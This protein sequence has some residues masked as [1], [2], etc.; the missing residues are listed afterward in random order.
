MATA[1][2]KAALSDCFK[3]SRVS[4]AMVK[5]IESVGVETLDDFAN[6]V[7]RDRYEEDLKEL[8]ARGPEQLREMDP[9]QPGA[10]AQSRLRAAYLLAVDLLKRSATKSHD[11]LAEDPSAPL[12]QPVRDQLTA[13]W[14]QHYHLQL[15]VELWPSDALVARVYREL[16]RGTATVIDVKKCRALIHACTPTE[17]KRHELG[18]GLQLEVG[19]ADSVQ[20]GSVID[21]YWGLRILAYAYAVAGHEQV[22]SQVTVKTKV[23][24]CPLDVNLDYADAALRDCM[25]LRLPGRSAL[26]WLRSRDTLTRGVMVQ[27]LRQGWPQGEALTRARREE[28]VAWK[29]GRLAFE[30]RRPPQDDGG[31]P[32]KRLRFGRGKGYGKGSWSTASPMLALED[33]PRKG[34]GKQGQMRQRQS[35][36]GTWPA[37]PKHI[38]GSTNHGA[39]ACSLSRWY[40]KI[41]YKDDNGN[42]L[43]Q[44]F[45]KG[46][47]GKQKDCKTGG[48]HKC[49]RITRE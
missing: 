3:K 32:T 28:D 41:A 11:D 21:Y 47:C 27:L 12:P 25:S 38:C 15:P 49:G 13:A 20:I 6:Y 29:S 2:A 5:F 26:A 34:A 17:R 35:G 46:Q 45:Q 4:E 42:A 14:A 37:N 23:R 48:L 31:R 36:S 24:N 1:E 22:E 33:A 43:C 8:Q 30:D 44:D 18:E 7:R 40:T 9:G 39:H 19:A 10:L 16:K